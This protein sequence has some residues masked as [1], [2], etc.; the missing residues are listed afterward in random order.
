MRESKLLLLEAVNHALAGDW[1]RAHEIV[2]EREDDEIA[3]W[4][5]G[6]VHWMEGDAGN[7]RYWYGRCGRNLAPDVDVDQE[8]RA[9]RALI[10]S[11]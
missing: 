6:V 2:Q 9:I 3:N 4:I 8:L 10:E 5:H 7:A 11:L 1:R